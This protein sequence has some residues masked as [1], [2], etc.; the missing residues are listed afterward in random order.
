MTLRTKG[1]RDDHNSVIDAGVSWSMRLFVVARNADCSRR[2][3]P[4][5]ARV[6]ASSRRGHK[7][8]R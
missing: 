6:A 2:R 5:K 4:I 3:Q 8:W 1:E 7:G